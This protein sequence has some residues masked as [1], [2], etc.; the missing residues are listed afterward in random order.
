MV[1]V[2]C[3]RCA[4]KLK[5]PDG[6]RRASARC[7]GC[8]GA[9]PIGAGE[10]VEDAAAVDLLGVVAADPVGPAPAAEEE[11]AQRERL[12]PAVIPEVAGPRRRKSGIGGSGMSRPLTMAQGWLIIVLLGAMVAISAWRGAPADRWEYMVVSPND[13]RFEY[14]MDAHGMMGW[15]IV[16]A[17]RATSEGADG[18]NKAGYEVIL[19]RRH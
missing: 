1:A 11:W 10:A 14:E 3:P 5:V 15:E 6:F 8:G 16:S 7:P 4:K 13:D 18:K 17:R 9:V 2:E 12:F 19:K